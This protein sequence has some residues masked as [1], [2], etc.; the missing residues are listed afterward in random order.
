MK[1]TL[2]VNDM[3]IPLNDFTQQYI[4]KILVGIAESL[5]YTGQRINLY[6]EPSDLN[7]F[8]DDTQ[9]PI[10]K[11]FVRLLIESTIK[12]VLSPLKGIFWLQRI[13][14]TTEKE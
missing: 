3:V 2:F 14:I 8:T 1:T 11:E 12:G 10:R 5:G 4:G 13:T 6:I 7:L 9:V